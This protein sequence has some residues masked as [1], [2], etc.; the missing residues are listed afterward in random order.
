[1]KAIAVIV[2]AVMLSGCSRGPKA[3]ES[4]IVQNGDGTYTVETWRDF[5]HWSSVGRG[6]KSTLE[7]AAKLQALINQEDRY[8]VTPADIAA[9]VERIKKQ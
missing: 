7:E 8:V 3:N 9:S 1:M 2:L 4:R 5:P 6:N